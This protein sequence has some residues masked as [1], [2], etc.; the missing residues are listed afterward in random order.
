[1]KKEKVGIAPDVLVR[2][3]IKPKDTTMDKILDAGMKNKVN[4]M[5]SDIVLLDVLNAIKD[6]ELDRKKLIKLISGVNLY[7]A[8]YEFRKK[9]FVSDK[10][11]ILH[12]RQVALKGDELNETAL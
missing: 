4:L 1:M 2:Y 6:D 10:K 8:T 7:A 5:V 11:R 9:F 3:F 12:L